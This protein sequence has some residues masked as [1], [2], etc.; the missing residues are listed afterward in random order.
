MICA[1]LLEGGIRRFTLF[2][3]AHSVAHFAREEIIDGK[4]SKKTDRNRC[5]TMVAHCG[6]LIRNAKYT[7][8]R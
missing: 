3:G 4:I 1:R 8:T 5:Q 6:G 2:R 7:G